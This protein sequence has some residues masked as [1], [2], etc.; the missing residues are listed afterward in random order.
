M[1]LDGVP[2]ERFLSFNR[3]K[4]GLKSFL[5]LIGTGINLSFNRTKVGLKLMCCNE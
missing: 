3:T 2:F 5:A 1:I 4:V